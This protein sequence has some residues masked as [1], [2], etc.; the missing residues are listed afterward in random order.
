MPQPMKNCAARIASAGGRK[1]IT[2]D[3]DSAA[4]TIIGPRID[5]PKRPTRSPPFQPM[6][7][8]AAMI[9]SSYH[10]RSATGL[11]IGLVSGAP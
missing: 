7:A 11:P 2:P 8:A 10:G 1:W 5:A 4:V 3:S 6:K 9:T